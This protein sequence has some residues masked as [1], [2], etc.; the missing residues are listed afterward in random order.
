MNVDFSRPWQYVERWLGRLIH[1]PRFPDV[2][3]SEAKTWY[4]RAKVLTE[5][6][7]RS[8][9]E[10][11][12]TVVLAMVAV[13]AA[14]A[15]IAP[16]HAVI[17][18]FIFSIPATCLAYAYMWL[19]RAEVRRHVLEH[20]QEVCQ[21]PT[22]DK[23]TKLPGERGAAA[24]D[25]AD[26]FER[27]TRR[28]LRSYYI[29][30]VLRVS[31]GED[32]AYTFAV[33]NDSANLVIPVHWI[34]Y[35]AKWRRNRNRDMMRKYRRVLYA[36]LLHELA[37]VMSQDSINSV[38]I[39]WLER[40]V[41]RCSKVLVIGPIVIV[42]CAICLGVEN[43]FIV[44]I[45]LGF[46]IVSVGLGLHKLVRQMRL[47]NMN[48]E[49]D[50]EYLADF[51]VVAFG[52]SFV[53]E[54][55]VAFLKNQTRV[56][57]LLR[58]DATIKRLEEIIRGRCLD[59]WIL[60][61]ILWCEGVFRVE[62]SLLKPHPPALTRASH[63]NHVMAPTQT[64]ERKDCVTYGYATDGN[65]RC[66]VPKPEVNSITVDWR[67]RGDEELETKRLD[68]ASQSSALRH[69]LLKTCEKCGGRSVYG[70]T[71]FTSDGLA[72][73][74]SCV[75]QELVSQG[76]RV[77]MLATRN[78]RRSSII[79]VLIAVAVIVFGIY[80]MGLP[81]VAAV[82]TF[83]LAEFFGAK[84]FNS[85]IVTQLVTTVATTVTTIGVLLVND[86]LSTEIAAVVALTA[87]AASALLGVFSWGL[88][89]S[90]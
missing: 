53:V 36:I 56:E 79:L 50:A 17:L 11:Q 86:Q 84:W 76:S 47:T 14:I 31:T 74:R 27:G 61:A 23:F 83:S 55:Y 19:V 63:L 5:R 62:S 48:I 26:L 88:S 73:C 3:T 28:T 72:V 45:F 49:I 18:F 12:G 54:E 52:D 34:N 22:L 78:R 87:F 43:A 90:D 85:G 33:S 60:R 89:I 9:R 7:L 20:F 32:G 8:A 51:A 24:R 2:E 1:D 13:P 21:L 4:Q 68:R 10:M 77:Q 30:I 71:T 57:A 82:L 35:L 66:V 67:S 42:P 81:I 58:E 69:E 6:R 29:D 38:S 70:D 40:W 25:I 37:H 59:S 80:F 65:H 44:G 39:Y 15:G 46:V 64:H 41:M 16:V 75:A